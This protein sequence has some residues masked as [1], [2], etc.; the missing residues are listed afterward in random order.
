[1]RGSSRRS[2]A[3]TPAGCIGSATA[4]TGNRDPAGEQFDKTRRCRPPLTLLGWRLIANQPLKPDRREKLARSLGVTV[5][6]LSHLGVGWSKQ[7]WG[8]TFPMSSVRCDAVD[9]V[10]GIRLRKPDGRKLSVCG[11]REG[12][13]IP[14]GL[15][16]SPDLLLVCEGPT[17]TAALLDLG[18]SVAGR[19]SCTGGVPLLVELVQH[20]SPSQ[21]VI[22]A[23]A[24][25]PG[26]RGAQSLAPAL[27]VYAPDVRVITPPT[28]VKDARAWCRGGATH[29]DVVASVAAATP[30]RSTVTAKKRKATR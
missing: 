14:R 6:S 19:P 10:R 22:V 26:Q 1:M 7:Y 23:D 3:A 21:V 16:R 24:D 17:D 2:A 18:F 15:P 29:G 30:R 12:L 11:S 25:T 9:M 8:W 13:F 20:K 4:K 27:V 5:D 28:G